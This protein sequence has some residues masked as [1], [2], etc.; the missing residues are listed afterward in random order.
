MTV[1]E[2]LGRLARAKENLISAQNRVKA[3]WGIWLQRE[4]V[5]D[6]ADVA[7]LLE[8]TIERMELAL[9]DVKTLRDNLKEGTHGNDQE[10]DEGN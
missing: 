9:H 2:A 7:K 4:A 6:E 5:R 10:I 3:I 8:D 1:E